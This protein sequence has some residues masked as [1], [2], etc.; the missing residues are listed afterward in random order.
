MIL[1]SH[2]RIATGKL[3]CL[4]KGKL[5]SRV[6]RPYRNREASAPY[7]GCAWFSLSPFVSRTRCFSCLRMVSFLFASHLRIA[8]GKLS[9]LTEGVPV[10]QYR[11]SYSGLDASSTYEWSASFSRPTFVSRPGS[12][13][14]H[15]YDMEQPGFLNSKKNQPHKRGWFSKDFVFNLAGRHL[16]G[17]FFFQAITR[18]NAIRQIRNATFAPVKYR[19]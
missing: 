18:C 3:R 4:T 13:G 15:L 6:P 14:M 17:P 16:A 12:Q 9:H 1:A 8:T 2:V 5:D 11:H 10:F 7:E 19:R